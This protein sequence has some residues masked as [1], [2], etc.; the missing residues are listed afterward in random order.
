MCVFCYHCGDEEPTVD[1]INRT[2]KDNL[3]VHYVD[4]IFSKNFKQHLFS[5]I[6]ILDF[7]K[8]KHWLPSMKEIILSSDNACCYLNDVV[9]PMSYIIVVIH[10]LNDHGY[11][12]SNARCAK[13]LLDCHFV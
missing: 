1:I 10:G 6:Y 3:L 4:H 9:A 12:H 11:V 13:V 8:L 2:M 5:N 7:E